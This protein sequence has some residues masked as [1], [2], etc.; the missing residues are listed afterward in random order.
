MTWEEKLLL[1]YPTPIESV[2]RLELSVNVSRKYNTIFSLISCTI[3]LD[4]TLFD[5]GQVGMTKLEIS[6]HTFK[7]SDN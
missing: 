5:Q 7:S 3:A 2:Y 4:G 6:F 1:K